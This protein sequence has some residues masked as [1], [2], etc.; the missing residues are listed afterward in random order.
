MAE[1]HVCSLALMPG[2]VERVQ[3]RSLL[4]LVGPGMKIERPDCVPPEQHLN[5]AL[6]DIV[7]PLLGYVVPDEGHVRRLLDFLFLWDQ[8]HPMVVHCFAGVSRSTAAAFIAACTLAPNAS[9]AALAA[10]IREVS[11]TATPNPRLV[12]LADDMLDREGRMSAAIAALGRGQDC[13]E[14]EP[15]A[16]NLKDW[17]K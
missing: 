3:A 8:R 9:E 6:S 10:Y 5:L 2:T 16:L 14:G 12:A 1:I 17:Q 13:Y 7:A 11:P 15:F 4:S